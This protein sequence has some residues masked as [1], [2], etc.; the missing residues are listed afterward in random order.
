[1]CETSPSARAK[2]CDDRAK[3]ALALRS[4]CCG[5]MRLVDDTMI[6][7]YRD[8][9]P[10]RKLPTQFARQRP[11]R[12][13]IYVLFGLILFAFGLS[14]VLDPDYVSRRSRMSEQANELLKEQ[15]R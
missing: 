6:V 5:R 4:H 12:W 7:R 8:I 14:L 10:P 9:E 15:G 1:M 3:P 2:I 11:R 13:P